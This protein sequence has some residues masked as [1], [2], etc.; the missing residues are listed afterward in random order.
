LALAPQ[1]ASADPGDRGKEK[2]KEQ[3]A[4]FFIKDRQKQGDDDVG[5]SNV[6]LA[7]NVT[8][9]AKGLAVEKRERWL[10]DV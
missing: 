1:Y 2:E 7:Q 10:Q 5:E 3:P 9:K 6:L 4:V 8:I